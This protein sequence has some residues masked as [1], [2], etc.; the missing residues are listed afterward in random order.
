MGNCRRY[1]IGR[2]DL[3]G[4]CRDQTATYTSG[5]SRGGMRGMHP[6]TGTSVA[7]FT[8]SLRMS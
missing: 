3:C 6:P 2:Y 7:Y 5:G 4:G 1:V 8:Q